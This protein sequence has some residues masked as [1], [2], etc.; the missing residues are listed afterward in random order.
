MQH[1]E[2]ARDNPI[3]AHKRRE[4]RHDREKTL[5]MTGIFL[6]A[7]CVCGLAYRVISYAVRHPMP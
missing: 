2:K 3:A 5:D 6:Y 4:M 7:F 1:S